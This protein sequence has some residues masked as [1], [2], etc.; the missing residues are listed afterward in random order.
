MYTDGK[1]KMVNELKLKKLTKA[2]AAQ[3]TVDNTL[4]ILMDFNIH[5]IG[6]IAKH[7]VDEMNN[8]EFRKFLNT[9]IRSQ[10]SIVA[11]WLLELIAKT[12]EPIGCNYD[13]EGIGKWVENKTNHIMAACE[14]FVF[15][16]V[17]EK[18]NPSSHNI[19]P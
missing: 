10:N 13:P 4:D 7:K 1:Y 5:I 8:Q 15:N 17:Q 16:I 2:L 3:E 6:K 11:A 14:E 18:I 12:N 19:R 9:L